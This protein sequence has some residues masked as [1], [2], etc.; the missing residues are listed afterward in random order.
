MKLSEA[1]MLGSTIPGEPFDAM[2]WSCCLLGLANRAVGE[3]TNLLPQHAEIRWP[4]MKKLFRSPAICDEWVGV[5]VSITHIL[6]GI[7]LNIEAGGATLEQA[8]DWIRS[9]EP[10]DTDH[11][12]SPCVG[13]GTHPTAQS[14]EHN[15]VDAK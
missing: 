5:E 11:E 10:Q 6:T 14:L 2:D 1:I 8:V 12:Q 9:V 3:T 4:W 15:L 7:A 13:H